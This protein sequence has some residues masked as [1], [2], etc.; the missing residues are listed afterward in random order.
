MKAEQGLCGRF[1]RSRGKGRVA[2]VAGSQAQPVQVL[3]EIRGAAGLVGI[4][5]RLVRLLR[6]LD[7]L[8]GFAP[9]LQDAP[10]EFQRRDLVFGD[11]APPFQL[12][13]IHAQQGL[14]RFDAVALVHE[15]FQH[16]QPR[17]NWDRGRPD[18]LQYPVFD[19]ILGHVLFL[20]RE[21]IRQHLRPGRRGGRGRALAARCCKADKGQQGGKADQSKAGL[22]E[23]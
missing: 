18:R 15:H 23:G 4:C 6:R 20:N 11:P 8:N 3:L 16:A 19:T 5:L 2:L 17:V 7:N 1:P 22:D 10:P 13:G 12:G 9:R 14:A 21:N